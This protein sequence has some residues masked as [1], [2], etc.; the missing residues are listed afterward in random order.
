MDGSISSAEHGASFKSPERFF[1]G[2]APD[3][4][5]E[6]VASA[7]DVALILEDGVIRDVALG[8][9]DLVQAGYGESWVGQPWID[10]VTVESRRKVE[11]LLGGAS[12]PRGHS[13]QVN[14]FSEAGLDVPVSYTAVQ[15]GGHRVAALGRDLR[16]MSAL[17]QRLVEAHQNLERDYSRLRSSEARYQLLFE[18]ISQP[19]VIVDSAALKIEEANAAAAQVLQAAESPVKELLGK[20]F[21]D[22][23]AERSRNEVESALSDSVAVGRAHAPRLETMH[24][25]LCDLSI[26][27]FRQGESTRSIVRLDVEGGRDAEDET[28]SQVLGVLEHIPD[29]FLVASA[30]QRVLAVNRAFVDLAH[31]VHKGQAVGARLGDFVGRSSTDLNVILSSLKTRAAVRHFATVV[32]DR[33]GNEEPVEI[34]AVATELETATLYGFVIRGTARR[35]PQGRSPGQQLPTSTDQ[36]TGLVGTLPLREIVRESTDIIERLCVEAALE[37]T[38]DNRASAAEILGLSRQGLYSKLRRFGIGHD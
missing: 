28:P 17:Q 1:A 2:L 34:S 23:F 27:A 24:G 11:E 8:S 32:R 35:V 20:P 37:I 10:T 5:A 12:E 13:R 22:F 16:P 36:L 4:T 21:V 30:D 19:I 14:H 25:K 29:G 6:I 3:L 9:H 33:F 7:A 26:S 31:L 38:G 15:M 18:S